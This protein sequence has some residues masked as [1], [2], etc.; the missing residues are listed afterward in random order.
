MKPISSHQA[1][2]RK[3]RG[4][5]TRSFIDKLIRYTPIVDVIG[6]HV[7]LKERGREYKGCCPFHHEENASFS[8][9]PEK[10]TYYCFSCQAKGN[11]INFLVDHLRLSFPDAIDQLAANA[12]L[13][14]EREPPA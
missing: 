1:H 2:S 3:A 9:N 7:P 14:V 11:V 6:E 10:G 12:G 5:I 8:V 4:R 13:E